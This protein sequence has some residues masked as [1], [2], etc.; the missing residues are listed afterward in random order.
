M[1][2]GLLTSRCLANCERSL[3]SSHVLGVDDI[4]SIVDAMVCSAVA[5]E[6]AW[7]VVGFGVSHG[8]GGGPVGAYD[9]E[10]LGGEEC[11]GCGCG[12]TCYHGFG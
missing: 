7:F 10:C 11:L 4:S 3:S 5:A 6:A 12:G 1:E 8:G 9:D 2:G